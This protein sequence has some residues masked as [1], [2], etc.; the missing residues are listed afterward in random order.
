LLRIVFQNALSENSSTHER[1]AVGISK[2]RAF[3]YTYELTSIGDDT[4]SSRVGN[5]LPLT[6]EN[7][8]SLSMLM[9]TLIKGN[10][11]HQLKTKTGQATTSGLSSVLQDKG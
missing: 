4:F 9:S 7:L 1:P 11:T 10:T 2:R 5:N 8:K 6:G 3:D